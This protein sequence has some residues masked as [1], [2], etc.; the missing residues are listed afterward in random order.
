MTVSTT[1]TSWHRTG[2]RYGPVTVVVVTVV[3]IGVV[4]S[5]SGA[6]VRP[7]DVAASGTTPRGPSSTFIDDGT[8][9]VSFSTAK[10]HNLPVTFGPG[11][12]QA[13]GKIALP[14][15]FA[16]EC[17]A[18]RPANGGATAPGVTGDA[19]KVVLYQPPPDPLIDQ[20]LAAIGF[21]DTAEDTLATYRGYIEIYQR[22]F[23][24]YGR[25]IDFVSYKGTGTSSDEVAAR[26]DAATIADELHPFAV[27]GGPFL[28]SAFGDEL[29]AR[30][31]IQFDLASSKGTKFFGEHA[32]Y[33]WNV[34]AAPD[35]TSAVVAEYLGKQLKGKPARYAGDPALASQTR[36]FGLL[37]LAIP[38]NNVEEL[39]QEFNDQLK[40]VGVD[41]AVQV[42]SV[43]P[44]ASA[45]QQ[46]AKLK[47]AGV[48]SVMF[49]GDPLSPKNFTEEATRQN[50]F[51]EW[52][53][54][55]STL[56]DSTTFARTYDPQ[57]WKHAFGISQ[58]FARGRPSANW[59]YALYHWYFGQEPP[60]VN[61]TQI[62]FPFPTILMSGIMGAGPNLTPD[63]FRQA[64][65]DAQPLGGGLTVP[66]VSF[67][68]KGFYPDADY[69]GIDDAVEIWY[70]PTATGPD[71]RGKDG[72]GMYRYV[73]GGKRYLPG[74]WPTEDPKV[75]TTDGSAVA[76]YET[77]PS[78]DQPAD[79]P[80]PAPV[81]TPS[82]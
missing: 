82:K 26:A 80:S 3:I 9:P 79:Y 52:I 68:T 61:G 24:L 73:D 37:F 19:I 1:E 50:Y 16:P 57:Q 32:P 45:A 54:T 18:Q 14:S 27:F 12:D 36:T 77:I 51:P 23:E 53:I 2:R 47:E 44:T 41:L 13:R 58:L 69:N 42:G 78:A 15:A 39:R 64:L 81:P 74:H 38:G 29:A 60:A 22:Y 43:D 40:A 8:R 33:N 34:L 72:T 25:K 4:V 66:Q 17:F 30:T 67:G 65:F 35:Q 20:I 62:I 75:F 63:T 6:P 28:T 46:I 76:L 10:E 48:T 70:D 5:R 56:T 7:S 11:C 71:E 49:V 55:G 31:I 59:S 21:N